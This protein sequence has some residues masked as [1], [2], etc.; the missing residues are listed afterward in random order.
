MSYLSPATTS[1][2]C[3]A[4]ADGIWKTMREREMTM[5][6]VLTVCSILIAGVR[7]HAPSTTEELLAR[8][9]EKVFRLWTVEATSN[10]APAS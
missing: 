2:A 10:P 7:E 5:E 1:P 9:E 6:D 4:M 3:R 8:I